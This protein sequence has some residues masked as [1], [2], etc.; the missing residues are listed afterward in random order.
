MHTFYHYLCSITD[1]FCFPRFDLLQIS[2]Q[3]TLIKFEMVFTKIDM[4][5]DK[6]GSSKGTLRYTDKQTYQWFKCHRRKILGRTWRIKRMYQRTIYA[7]RYLFVLQH[8]CSTFDDVLEMVTAA[9]SKNFKRRFFYQ[10]ASTC[11][12]DLCNVT[13]HHIFAFW[14]DSGE[15]NVQW[16]RI[17]EVF[18]LIPYWSFYFSLS[19]PIVTGKFWPCV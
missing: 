12:Y 7:E 8:S 4:T 17:Q 5:R 16:R 13:C 2:R 18:P 10:I 11:D 19:L 9:M 6:K 3:S 1:C 15:G 14:F